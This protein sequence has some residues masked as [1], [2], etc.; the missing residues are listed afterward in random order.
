MNILSKL[1]ASYKKENKKRLVWGLHPMAILADMAAWK[2][3]F[4]I[5]DD[6]PDR[7]SCRPISIKILHCVAE[8]KRTACFIKSK[9]LGLHAKRMGR[10]IRTSRC[11][12]DWLRR[13]SYA[14]EMIKRAYHFSFG[15]SAG[16]KGWK[17]FWLQCGQWAGPAVADIHIVSPYSCW[18]FT[19]R[20]GGCVKIMLS[21]LTARNPTNPPKSNKS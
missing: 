2:Q 1:K 4:R 10:L 7:T 21:R 6:N 14:M 5:H 19:W 20:G 8:K 13:T 16:L 3:V 15:L 17:G 12:L 9:A 18:V 11:A